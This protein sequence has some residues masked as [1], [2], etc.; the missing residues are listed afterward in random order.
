MRGAVINNILQA[1]LNSL[2]SSPSGIYNILKRYGK[3]RFEEPMK[4]EK[5][6]IIKE[7]AGELAH[8]DGHHLSKDTST[9]DKNNYYIVCVIDA[10][11]RIAWAEVTSDLKAL[12]VVCSASSE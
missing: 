2:T 6:R 1:K 12:T 11:T 8:I 9:N 5:R 4:E 7:K 10:H 3:N